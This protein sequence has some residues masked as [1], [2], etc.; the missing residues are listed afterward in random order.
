VR[1]QRQAGK[2]AK[3]QQLSIFTALLSTDYEI[4]IA[5]GT[6]VYPCFQSG[7]RAEMKNIYEVLKQKEAQIQQLQK[8]IDALRIA[9]RLLS[10]DG[11]ME[12]SVRPMS[13]VVAGTPL[14]TV[15]RA[16]KENGQAGWEA[17]TKQFP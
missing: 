15:P 6:A 17:T 8:E 11:E 1:R 16:G 9:A 12:P 3:I 5:D 2:S 4:S 14:A 10:E 7:E 13:S